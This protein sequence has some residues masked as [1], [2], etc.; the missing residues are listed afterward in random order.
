[1]LAPTAVITSAVL[2]S[3]SPLAAESLSFSKDLPVVVDTQVTEDGD[4]PLDPPTSSDPIYY[5]LVINGFKAFGQD[6]AGDRAPNP[7]TLIAQVVEALVEKGYMPADGIN[8]AT[9][10]IGLTW[11][12]LREDPEVSARYLSGQQ[13]AIDWQTRPMIAQNRDYRP[14]FDWRDLDR[15][16]YN[17]VLNVRDG[18]TYVMFIT[19]CD[20]DPDAKVETKIYW[21]TRTM[22]RARGVR[23]SEALAKAVGPMVN[24]F[25]KHSRVPAVE[26][27]PR[28]AEPPNTLTPD[29]SFMP[30]IH[31]YSP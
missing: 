21:Q 22:I 5:N 24:A 26:L 28:K 4:Y 17:R 9:K 15:T 3:A 7:N 12:S 11:G 29:S 2:A 10:T 16:T 19:L 25:G 31:D 27:V 1:M 6:L 30:V 14:E 23:A 8:P 13:H 18:D 20:W